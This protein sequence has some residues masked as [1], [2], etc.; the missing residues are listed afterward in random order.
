MF[1]LIPSAFLGALAMLTFVVLSPAR[2]PGHWRTRH[3]LYAYAVGLCGLLVAALVP[4]ASVL[5][6]TFTEPDAL[7]IVLILLMLLLGAV[8]AERCIA[9]ERKKGDRNEL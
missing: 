2:R 3:V 8:I 4:L 6:G 1:L 9:L 5:N 7:Q